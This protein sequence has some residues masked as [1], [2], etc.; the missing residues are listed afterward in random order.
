[1]NTIVG[2]KNSKKK[3]DPTFGRRLRAL[4]EA[5]GWSQAKLGET[6]GG[7]R[8]QYIARLERAESEAGWEMATRL[9]DALGVSLDELRGVE[10]N[11]DE[12]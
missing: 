7:V 6:A 1:M 8:Y 11:P 5:R 12:T 3:V 9:A 2:E 10:S 4:R